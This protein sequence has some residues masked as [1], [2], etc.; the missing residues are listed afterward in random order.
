MRENGA[1]MK[2]NSVE[3]R[4]LITLGLSLLLSTAFASKKLPSDWQQEV[5]SSSQQSQ[6]NQNNTDQAE[7][8]ILKTL[9]KESENTPTSSTK[10]VP[11]NPNV[12][13]KKQTIVKK[14]QDIS[15]K[16]LK[17]IIKEGERK[18]NIITMEHGLI[19]GG[20]YI[21]YLSKTNYFYYQQ[22]LPL[23]FVFP[24]RIFRVILFG[25][26]VKSMYYKR[27]LIYFPPSQVEG[28]VN[29]FVVI[30]TDGSSSYFLG[31]RVDPLFWKQR[32]Q[33]VITYY[34][35]MLKEQ[36]PMRDIVKA[37]L[38]TYHRCPTDGEVVQVGGYSYKFTLAKG[39]AQIMLPNEV[40]MC[41]HVFRVNRF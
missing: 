11:Y 31:K 12:K 22:N 40:Y 28:T 41:G 39:T 26:R 4:T 32:N 14:Y 33:P 18:I 19:A 13:I 9:E 5:A 35:Y 36:L 10:I 21:G 1:H 29:G 6:Q 38:Q 30:F 37:F 20:K 7:Q 16:R 17:K 8:E 3:K 25:E 27:S 2:K 24:K 34:Q 15:P 23:L